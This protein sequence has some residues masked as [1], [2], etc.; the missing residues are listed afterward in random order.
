[1]AFHARTLRII[2]LAGIATLCLALVKPARADDVPVE[3][4]VDLLTRVVK[5]ERTFAADAQSVATVLIVAKP[6][7]VL[8]TRA[9]AQ[10]ATA[11]KQAGA[12]AGRKLNVVVH[13]FGK[14]AD[15][16]VAAAQSAIVYV[17]PG[18]TEE[19]KSIAEA[20]QGMHVLVVAARS[21]DVE[22]GASLAFELESARPRIVIN[23][24]QAKAHNLDF[25]SQLLRLAKVIP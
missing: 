14:V 13:A 24:P 11:L 20:M 21:D 6:G 5:F 18:L 15:L 12:L 3:L 2:V 9:G 19:F 23:L 4:Q 22:R 10:S 8:S 16:K 7:V 1:M 25:N 17:M